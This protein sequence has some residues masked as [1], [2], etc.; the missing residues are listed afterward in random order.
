MAN[1]AAGKVEPVFLFVILPLHF[2]SWPAQPRAFDVSTE[3]VQRTLVHLRARWF[4]Y[5]FLVFRIS[6]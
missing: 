4:E 6:L 1:G 5:I 3:F 2:P